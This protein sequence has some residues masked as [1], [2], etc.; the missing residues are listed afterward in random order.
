MSLLVDNQRHDFAFAQVSAPK[1]HLLPLDGMEGKH[2][3][4]F[5]WRF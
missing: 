2:G 3:P 4:R 5:E 1:A